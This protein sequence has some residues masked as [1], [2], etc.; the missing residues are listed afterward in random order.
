M[1]VIYLHLNISSIS[2]I[3]INFL[4]VLNPKWSM[5]IYG[6]GNVCSSSSFSATWGQCKKWKFSKQEAELDHQS[7]SNL[8]FNFF[9]AIHLNIAFFFCAFFSS[10]I[11][12]LPFSKNAVAKE[13]S[14]GISI[15]QYHF[16]LT[17]ASIS[18]NVANQKIKTLCFD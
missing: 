14:Y 10:I 18:L 11:M 5:R 4:Q 17:A 8:I 9:E 12:Y 3:L 7:C 1:K 16:C 2:K 15:V 6:W 13:I